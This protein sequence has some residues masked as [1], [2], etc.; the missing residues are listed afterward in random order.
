MKSN[1]DYWAF[2]PTGTA[3]TSAYW[4]SPRRRLAG[5]RPRVTEVTLSLTDAE[6]AHLHD[7]ITT[8]TGASDRIPQWAGGGGETRQR[9][10]GGGTPTSADDLLRSATSGLSRGERDRFMANL[11]GYADPKE[12]L[13]EIYAGE[14][15]IEPGTGSIIHLHGP[16]IPD[17]TTPDDVPID[18]QDPLDPGQHRGPPE[19]TPEDPSGPPPAAP[20]VPEYGEGLG[21]P[22]PT[23]TRA[24][25]DGG[26][27]GL[28]RP[29]QTP[30]TPEHEQQRQEHGGDLTPP[31]PT[32][33]R[34]PGRWNLEGEYKWFVE[35][36]HGPG[37]ESP[38]GTGVGD[39]GGAFVRTRGG[40]TRFIGLGTIDPSREGAVWSHRHDR[41]QPA[42]GDEQ[43]TG[44]GIRHHHL[45]PS[46]ADGRGFTTQRGHFRGERLGATRDR[47]G[48]AHGLRLTTPVPA[49]RTPD[50]VAGGGGR[51]GGSARQ[52]S[53]ASA[54]RTGVLELLLDVV[55]AAVSRARG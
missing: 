13:R 26:S 29:R 9:F 51:W 30:E 34:H 4:P 52:G 11:R 17:P 41:T 19:L 32:P 7:V 23:P 44:Q 20:F 1:G 25:G 55:G 45:D 16:H 31:T 50:P 36:H 3:D 22:T 43:G 24:R 49:P 12:I 18:P 5:G 39:G 54:Q 14:A 35:G 38:E 47:T 42:A 2:D 37:G 21:A 10:P 28:S 53:G 8:L 27:G 6:L 33:D 48:R 15:Y 46:V 40:G